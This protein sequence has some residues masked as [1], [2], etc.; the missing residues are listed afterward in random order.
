MILKS[1]GCSFIYGS[2]LADDE[3]GRSWMPPSR[4]TWPSLIAQKFNLEYKCYARPG[5]GN[6]RILESLLAHLNDD[7]IFVIGWTWIDRFDYT[8]T[9]DHWQTI[10]P[11]DSTEVHDLYY[12]ELHSQY[13]DKLTTLIYIKSAIDA[14]L[15]LDRR[16]IMVYQDPL[17]FETQWHASPAIMHLQKSIKPYM[18]DFQGQPFLAWAQDK[19]YPISEKLHPLELAHQEAS[20]LMIPAIDAIRHKV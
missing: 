4:L 9:E 17:I 8:T 1:F 15:S 14:L 6:L 16:F 10:M 5:I 20:N 7:A 3:L 12:R 11:N 19:G 2:D 18:S 13:R